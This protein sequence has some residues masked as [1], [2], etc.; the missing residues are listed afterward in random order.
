M[1]TSPPN[2]SPSSKPN[3]IKSFNIYGDIDF[4]IKSNNNNV[5]S[6]R[7]SAIFRFKPSPKQISSIDNVLS[8]P[9]GKVDNSLLVTFPD[10][11]I[12]FDQYNTDKWKEM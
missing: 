5:S 10:S 6:R 7:N 4:N 2:S 8:S 1:P 9:S 3:P 12:Q 11:D